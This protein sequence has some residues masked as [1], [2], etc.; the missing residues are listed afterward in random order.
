MLHFADATC[1]CFLR[2]SNLW[3]SSGDRYQYG[4]YSNGSP[5]KLAGSKLVGY[6]GAGV[7]AG[8]GTVDVQN[9]QFDSCA[10]GVQGAGGNSIISGNAFNGRGAAVL[11]GTAL[12]STAQQPAPGAEG[13]VGSYVINGNMVEDD[14]APQNPTVLLSHAATGVISGNSFHKRN[15]TGKAFIIDLQEG[16]GDAAAGTL[17]TGNSFRAAGRV[18]GGQAVS[19]RFKGKVANNLGAADSAGDDAVR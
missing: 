16:D 15:A 17:L 6:A 11:N 4:V 13:F 14:S 10:I 3:A 9:N 12:I 8:G 7:Y 1:G 18:A 19:P 5:V 2:N